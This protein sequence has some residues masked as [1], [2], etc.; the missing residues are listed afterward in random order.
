MSNVRP[1]AH[2]LRRQ[3]WLR[4]RPSMLRNVNTACRLA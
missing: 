2:E 1:N 4:E 3:Q